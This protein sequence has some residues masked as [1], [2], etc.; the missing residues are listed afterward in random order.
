MVE[1]EQVRKRKMAKQLNEQRG[2]SVG[3]R[4][5]ASVS[6]D[7]PSGWRIE[8]QSAKSCVW[9]DDRGKRYESSKQVEAMLMERGLHG[10]PS[11]TETETDTALCDTVVILESYP[12]S[13]KADTLKFRT[14]FLI[15]RHTC[16]KCTQS[17]VICNSHDYQDVFSVLYDRQREMRLMHALLYA[18]LYFI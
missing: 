9:F 2:S 13:S 7:L 12:A 17:E 6:T 14:R 16:K 18:Q 1:R 10:L 11:E 8:C 4:L 3:S 5:S 15:M